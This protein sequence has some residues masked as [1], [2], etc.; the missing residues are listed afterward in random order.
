MQQVFNDGYYAEEDA[1][2][3]ENGK[4]V[5]NDDIDISDLIQDAEPAGASSSK[6]KGKRRAAAD[7][8][9]KEGEGR[10][11][12]DADFVDGAD[13]DA[14][15]YPDGV[16]PSTL[17]KKERKKLKKKQKKTAKKEGGVE[18]AEGIDTEAMDA[19][20]LAKERAA[21]EEA[22]LAK[23]GPEERKKRISDMLDE[24]Y[25]MDYEDLVSQHC[26]RS[27]LPPS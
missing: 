14:G 5:W 8:G 19:D 10:I 17:S 7:G 27:L 2:F 24:Y 22:E 16:D 12:M 11:E 3:D 9:D 26:L 4:P 15:E 6:K 18:G 1:E 21:K 20:H 13:D 23:L 25:N